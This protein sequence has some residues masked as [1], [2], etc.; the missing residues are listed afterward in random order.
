[1]GLATSIKEIIQGLAQKNMPNIVIGT[2]TQVSPLRVT[3]LNDLAVNLSA[4]SLTI[5]KRLKPLVLENQY[6]MLSFDMGNSWYMLDEVDE[7]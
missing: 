4:A 7:V 6:Y 1:V 5:P 3:L 2:V